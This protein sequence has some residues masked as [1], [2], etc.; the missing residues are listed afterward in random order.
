MD[1]LLLILRLGIALVLY[2]FLG[3]ILFLLLRDLRGLSAGAQAAVPSGRL[4]VVS[5]E[6]SAVEIGAEFRLQPFTSLGRS[7]QNIVTISDS[8]ASTWNSLLTWHDGHWWLEDRN[9]R[10]G[11]RINDQAISGSTVVSSNDIIGIGLTQL[12]LEVD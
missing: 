9:S 1:I 4:I 7:S 12:K 5:S 10:N 6:D 11:T 3:A 2:G 8:Y